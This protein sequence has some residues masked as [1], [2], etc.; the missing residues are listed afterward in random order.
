MNNKL[1]KGERIVRMASE[2]RN[3]N[4]RRSSRK[5]N[6]NVDAFKLMLNRLSRKG[7]INYTVTGNRVQLHLTQEAYY[8]RAYVVM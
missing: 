6:Q 3:L 5:L 1:N 4:V 7:L 8:R 2:K